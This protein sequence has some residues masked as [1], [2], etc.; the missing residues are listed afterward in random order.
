[1]K[2]VLLLI[3]LAL[4]FNVSDLAAT[5]NNQQTID[6]SFKVVIKKHLDGYRTDPRIMVY[7]IT[8]FE[9]DNVKSGWR[10]SKCVVT[11]DYSY[12]IQETGL[13]NRP[14]TAHLIFKLYTIVSGPYP[15]R[16]EAENAEDLGK[17]TTPDTYRITFSYQNGTWIPEKYETQFQVLPTLPPF[18]MAMDNINSAPYQRV[19]IRNP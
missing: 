14:Y 15:T 1:M 10:K 2:R 11:G 17:F 19:I 13:V 12:D 9:K 4:L 6:D 5:S 16:E 8:G 3:F 7:D 18:W